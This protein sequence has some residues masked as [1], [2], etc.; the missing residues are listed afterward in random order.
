MLQQRRSDLNRSQLKI[1]N[2][3]IQRQNA[4]ACDSLGYSC[5][6]RGGAVATGGWKNRRLK[7]NTLHWKIQTL[8]D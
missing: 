5:P 6:S 8:E 1:L 7:K 4:K 3:E 2:S